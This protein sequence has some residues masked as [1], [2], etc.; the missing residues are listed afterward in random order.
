MR[1]QRRCLRRAGGRGHIC[2]RWLNY[3]GHALIHRVR[4]PL[5]RLLERRVF[6]CGRQL[7]KLLP[8]A[9]I[10]NFGIEGCRD[11]F[12]GGATVIQLG[13]KLRRRIFFVKHVDDSLFL[14]GCC[15]LRHPLIALLSDFPHIPI[16]ERKIDS[17]PKEY[18]PLEHA[19]CTHGFGA[20]AGRALAPQQQRHVAKVA[21]VR[22]HFDHE[23]AVL[24]QNLQ[25]TRIDEV[26]LS[27][28]SAF[29]DYG[30]TLEIGARGQTARDAESKCLGGFWPVQHRDRFDDRSFGEEIY[31][32]P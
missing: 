23:L 29:V 18:V 30:F 6:L 9:N 8:I 3:G 12:C 4:C 2:L 1:N 13:E 27:A 21:P 25:Q 28:D 11:L 32:V 16:E 15:M 17:K 7:G 14:F 24:S 19:E 26:H 20:N 31:F 5:N 22:K 10:R